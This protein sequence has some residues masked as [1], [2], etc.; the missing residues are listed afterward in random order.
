METSIIT[1]KIIS[2]FVN[3]SFTLTMPFLSTGKSNGALLILANFQGF[4]ELFYFC[5][6]KVLLTFLSSFFKEQIAFG[7]DLWFN[8]A[9]QN[10]FNS[11]NI[12]VYMR[13]IYILYRKNSFTNFLRINSCFSYK[14]KLTDGKIHPCCV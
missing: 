11:I 2:Q 6:P 4:S 1:F 10:M 7:F 9:K 8:F 5:R 14:T 12:K 3:Q 13:I